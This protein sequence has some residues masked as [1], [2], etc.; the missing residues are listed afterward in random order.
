MSSVV[1]DL[2]R[3]KASQLPS[4]S[5]FQLTRLHGDTIRGKYGLRWGV[6]NRPKIDMTNY[7]NYEVQVADVGRLDKISYAFYKREDLWW[8][9]ASVNNIKDPLAEMY[10][11]MALKIPLESAVERALTEGNKA[12]FD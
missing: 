6:W 11:G 5:R 2:L 9:I 1:D 3:S 4:G 12:L 7:Y 8:A 10:P